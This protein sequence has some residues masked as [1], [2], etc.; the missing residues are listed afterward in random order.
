VWVTL[1]ADQAME[2]VGGEGLGPFGR[3]GVGRRHRWRRWEVSFR[4][5]R[6]NAG[7]SEHLHF[8]RQRGCS[9]CFLFVGWAGLGPGLNVCTCKRG[10]VEAENPKPPVGRAA[11]EL[12]T[13]EIF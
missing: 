6:R 7:E 4:G 10:S 5:A 2:V 11:S 8:V 9:V 1:G 13:V 12:K 3:D